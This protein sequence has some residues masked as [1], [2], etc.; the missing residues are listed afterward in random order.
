MEDGPRH[1]EAKFSSGQDA[2]ML[3]ATPHKPTHSRKN[4]STR[5]PWEAKGQNRSMHG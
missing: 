3:T 1:T 4:G 5:S 2:H